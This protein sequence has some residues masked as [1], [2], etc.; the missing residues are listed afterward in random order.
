MSPNPPPPETV[1]LVRRLYAEGWTN[2][3]IMAA[4]GITSVW[5]LYRCLDGLYPDGSEMPLPLPKVPRRRKMLGRQANRKM[6]I[7]RLWRSAERQVEQIEKRMGKPDTGAEE[8]ERDA[9]SAA[10]V[11]RMLR[12]LSSLDAAKRDKAKQQN[13]PDDASVPRNLDDLRREL[14][15]KIEAIVQD[16]AEASG[17][18]DSNLPGKPL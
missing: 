9:R 13:Q 10:I 6:L 11:V 12:E 1:A 3:A 17:R 4:T 15:R 5:Q 2:K 8:L 7:E 18:S 14:A 16:D